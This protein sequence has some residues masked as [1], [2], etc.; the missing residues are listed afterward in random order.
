[1]GSV[2]Q[3]YNG[4]K[5]LDFEVLRHDDY[6]VPQIADLLIYRIETVGDIAAGGRRR[7]D[8][9]NW[10]SRLRSED[11]TDALT[12]Q[13]DTAIEAPNVLENTVDLTVDLRRCSYIFRRSRLSGVVI[14]NLTCD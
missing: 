4:V 8:T 11:A 10:V 13:G 12:K 9:F 7:I 14:A 2:S 6:T 1:M 5:S 3:S